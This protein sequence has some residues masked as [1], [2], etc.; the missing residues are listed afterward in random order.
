MD[1][2][3]KVQQSLQKE[4]LAWVSNLYRQRLKNLQETE[5]QYQAWLKS[6]ESVKE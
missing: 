4:E 5:V 3:I 1:E 6:G 2:M